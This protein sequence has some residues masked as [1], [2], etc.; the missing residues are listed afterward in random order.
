M[1]DQH[2]T[3]CDDSELWLQDVIENHYEVALARAT[4]LL[5]QTTEDENGCWVRPTRRRPKLRF[6]GRQVSAARFVYCVVNR[7]V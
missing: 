5:T 2:F 4:S 7:V 6:R 3:Y 1:T